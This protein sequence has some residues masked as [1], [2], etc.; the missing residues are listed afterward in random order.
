LLKTADMC[1]EFPSDISRLTHG[2]TCAKAATVIRA[3]VAENE[4][5]RLA[6]RPFSAFSDANWY[7][8]AWHPIQE[9]SQIM[10]DNSAGIAI[11]YGDLCR[12]RAALGETK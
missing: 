5:L 11:T 4:R 10:V 12:A 8:T 6:L 2:I 3:L 1:A 7:L 9:D